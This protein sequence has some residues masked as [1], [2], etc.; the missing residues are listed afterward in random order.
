MG[1]ESFSYKFFPVTVSNFSEITSVSQNW[2]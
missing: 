1:K 2:L